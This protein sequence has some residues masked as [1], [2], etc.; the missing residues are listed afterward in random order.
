METTLAVLGV[1][2]MG[3]A[4]RYVF[5]RRWFMGPWRRFCRY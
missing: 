1:M 5:L 4:C 2:P 3:N